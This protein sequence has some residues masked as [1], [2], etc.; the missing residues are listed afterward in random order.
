METKFC[1]RCKTT[2]PIGDFYLNRGRSDGL[3]GYCVNCQRVAET[4]RKHK[5]RLRIIADLGGKCRRCGFDD[6][7]ALQ[8]DHVNGDG[9]IDRIEH[10]NSN[11][12]TFYRTV[13]ANPGRYMLMCANC[14]W[15]KRAEE[16]EVIG[17]RVY[18]RT[19][20]QQRRQGEGR[21]SADVNARRSAAVRRHQEEHPEAEQERAEKMRR[22][23]TGRKLVVGPDGKRHWE[24]PADPS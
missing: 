14:N 22:L 6:P 5:A 17:R 16:E 9:A 19:P 11:S 7:R 21:W 10:P 20:P 23:A 24:Y 13:L 3:S 12:A 4:D 8:I 18:E 2:K 15:I 1:P